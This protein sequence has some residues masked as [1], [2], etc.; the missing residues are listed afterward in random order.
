MEGVT[1]LQA[2]PCVIT[3]LR[4]PERNGYAAVQLGFEELG[5]MTVREGVAVKQAVKRPQVKP[6]TLPEV[7]HL[8]RAGKLFRHLREVPVKELGEVQVGQVVDVTMFQPGDTVHIV[9]TSKGK[10]FAGSVKRH[11]FHGGP[12]TH[13]QSDRHRAPGSVG[14]TTYAGRTFK[15]LKMAGHMGTNQVTMRNLTVIKVDAERNILFV[16]GS[17]PGGNKGIV[18]VHKGSSAPAAAEKK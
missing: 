14:S 8:R 12:K 11:G 6:L 16:A 10:G 13:G 15:G 17:V 3:E 5:E 1:A 4:Q 7:G 9:G 18:L 2:G